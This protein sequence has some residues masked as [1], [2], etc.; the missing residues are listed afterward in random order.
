MLK[1][2][3]SKKKRKQQYLPTY[4]QPFCLR[5]L[6]KSKIL[7]KKIIKKAAKEGE[8]LYCNVVPLRL[9]MV[10]DALMPLCPVGAF[11]AFRA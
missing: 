11:R 10:T 2:T 5:L 9:T 4:A 3:S 8:A 1:K 6:L 7:T